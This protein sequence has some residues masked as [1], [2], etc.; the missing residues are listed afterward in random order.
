MKRILLICVMLFFVST[1]FSQFKPDTIVS[2]NKN[3]SDD[4]VFVRQILDDSTMLAKRIIEN[5][6]IIQLMFF[7][8]YD[9]IWIE[10]S[11]TTFKNGKLIST[12]ELDSQGNG[13]CREYLEDGNISSVSEIK[14]LKNNGKYFEFYPNGL[15][16]VKGFF[17]DYLKEREWI[18][19]SENGDTLKIENYIVTD[20]KSLPLEMYSNDEI[21]EMQWGGT[22]EYELVSMKHGFTKIFKDGKLES[23]MEYERGREVK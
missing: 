21:N 2:E 5:K 11:S 4:Y 17:Y 15:F 16:K 9:S 3:I 7:D 1:I 8:Y 6:G 19:F 18:T 23:V 10:K 14:R 12:R 20:S 13:V 22:I